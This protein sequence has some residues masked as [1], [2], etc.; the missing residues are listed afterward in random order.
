MRITETKKK[1]MPVEDKIIDSFSGKGNRKRNV[2]VALAA[3]GMTPAYG[4]IADAADAI[5]YATEGEFGEAALSLAAM[6]PIAGQFVTGRRAAKVAKESGEKMVTLYRGIS[7]WVPGKMA[8]KGKFIGGRHSQWNPNIHKYSLPK[9]SI[10][11]SAAET[12]SRVQRKIARKEAKE[13]ARDTEENYWN[14]QRHKKIKRG[15]VLEFEMPLSEW[16]KLSVTDVSIAP[17]TSNRFTIFPPPNYIIHK[18]IPKEFLKKV[19]N[20]DK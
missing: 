8:K 3:A 17:L 2:H 14:R 20:L 4:N 16:K 10:S 15:L 19:H 11:V 7:D 13:W 5:L 6:V 1:K 12:E 18:G 9:G